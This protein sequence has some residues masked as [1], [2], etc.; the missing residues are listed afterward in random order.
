Y[1]AESK[2]ESKRPLTANYVQPQY[3]ARGSVIPDAVAAEGWPEQV[4]AR[5]VSRTGD[6]APPCDP[7]DP[8]N[9]PLKFQPDTGGIA[10]RL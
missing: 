3:D 1:K 10:E 2:A 4:V 9:G 5:V 6:G 7:A 8:A